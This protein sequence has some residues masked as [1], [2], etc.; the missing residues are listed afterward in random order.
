MSDYAAY[1]KAL[2]NCE[3]LCNKLGQK[4]MDLERENAELLVQ[5][6]C[7]HDWQ[8]QAGEP[9]FDSCSKCGLRRE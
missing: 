4:V 2:E 8:E 7:D 6:Q 3:R 1:V 5:A 9:P